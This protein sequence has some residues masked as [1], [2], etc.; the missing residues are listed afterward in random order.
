M[1]EGVLCHEY[2]SFLRS[3]FFFYSITFIEEIYVH[4]I[5]KI[6]QVWADFNGK[7]VAENS[8]CQLLCVK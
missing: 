5:L 4:I 2:F 8:K 1:T 6:S 7:K 3:F